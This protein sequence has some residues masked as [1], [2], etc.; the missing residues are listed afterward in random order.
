VAVGG[1]GVPVVSA[2]A[3]GQ[4]AGLDQVN[5]ELPASLAGRGEVGVVLSAN[6]LTANTVLINMR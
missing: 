6:G 5:I 2:G 1:I 4:F 3:Q